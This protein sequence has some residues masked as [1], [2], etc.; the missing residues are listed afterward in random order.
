LK[1]SGSVI[2]MSEEACMIESNGRQICI[3]PSQKIIRVLGK[4]YTLLIVG[5]LG[6][7]GEL[8]FNEIARAVG[9]PRANLLSQRLRE[10]EEVGLA[11]RRIIQQRP[12]RVAYS[13]TDAGLQLRKLLI[14]VFEWLESVQNN[15]KG[16]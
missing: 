4:Q 16:G 15:D 12:V 10:L 5:L 6:N 2:F 8:G 1:S 14:P 7:R 11:K 13:L 9:R 3:Y